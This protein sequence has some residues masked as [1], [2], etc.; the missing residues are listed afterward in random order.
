MI[1]SSLRIIFLTLLLGLSASFVRAQ[2]TLATAM[3]ETN[4]FALRHDSAQTVIVYDSKDAGVIETSARLF[5]D[6]IKR[7]T[8]KTVAVST[9]PAANC[10]V[11]GTLGQSA[12][13]DKWAAEG[14]LADIDSIRG[15]W[16][17]YTIQLIRDPQPGV[18]T[19]LVIAGSDRRG[20]AYGLLSISELIGVSPWYWWA[21]VPV[22]KKSEIVLQV[23][24][25]VS[26]PPTVKYRGIF[27]NDED[28]GLTNWAKNT[29][30]PGTKIGPK[31]YDKVC[32]LMLRMKAN[33]L[34]PA[35]HGSSDPFNKYP[36]NK[37]IADSYAIVMGSTHCEPLLFNNATEWD[38][39]TMG[40][41]NFAQ[42]R[43]M[44]SK[45]LRQRVKENGR[46]ENVYTLALRGVHDKA[47][48]GSNKMVDRVRTLEAAI[49]DQ[50]DIL[51]DVIKKPLTDIP[52]AFT[53]YKEV[54]D[55]YS[56]GLKVPDEVTL[57]WADDN[58]GYMKRL[59]DPYE[60]KRSGRA[61]V[62]YHVSYLGRPHDYLWMGSNSPALMYEE[63]RKAYDTTAD[64]IWLLNVGD[65]KS[66]EF[67]M[68]FFIDMAW[69][70]NAF[71][72]TKVA[73]Y[74]A[75][76]LSRMFG[77]K[78]YRDYLDVTTNFYRLAFSR[79]PELMGWGY[80]WNVDQRA[81]HREKITDTEFS[82]VNYKE[83]E[84]RLADYDRIGKLADR[85]M[86]GLPKDQQPAFFQ[87]VY[88][89]VRGAE[90]MNRVHLNAQK[91]RM[92]ARQGRAATNGI[93]AD[94]EKY[95]RKLEALTAI[96][97]NQL[98]GKWNGM[99]QLRM[100][101]PTAYHQLP[102]MENIQLPDT[103]DFGIQA[104]GEDV[105][106]GVRSYNALPCF[107]P[108]LQRGYY[109]DI[110]NK[111][112]QSLSW[113]LTTSAPWIVVTRN[114]GE[115]LTENR[116]VVGVDWNKVPDGEENLL[117]TIEITANNIKKQVLVSAFNPAT[118]KREE[119]GGIYI[120]DNG[121]V[122]I[123]AAGFARKKENNKIKM[124]MINNLGFEDKCVQFG[125]PV[126]SKHSPTN[127]N[128]PYVEYDFYTFHAGQVDVYT[129][130]LP[131]YQLFN[132]PDFAGHE[133][134]NAETRFG[135]RIDGGAIMAP[136]TSTSEY[137]KAWYDNVVRNCAIGKS[138]LY[139]DKPGKHTL[140]VIC[141]TPGLV[142]QK[143]VID[144]GGMKRS[145]MGP[146]STR[147]SVRN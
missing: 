117:G 113:T 127:L 2:V 110:Y 75:K 91:N 56:H 131:T 80:E 5:S 36:E 121:I 122:S 95:Y 32:E 134:T 78:N 26:K 13:I 66:C 67:H 43:D 124:R 97:N 18:K 108:Y 65:I 125:N 126:Q 90:L 98:D 49:A 92:Y 102:P 3:N 81:E 87:L 129:Y 136:T 88:Y 1:K 50:R 16:E 27:I 52:Q 119:V 112:T 132:D 116:V 28:W 8:K 84:K 106:S 118:P 144:L 104:E 19:A 21:D 51:S 7:V 135:I 77:E 10:V 62:Y 30:E 100:G 70:I 41:W 12:L 35:M 22:A 55:V 141:G 96:Y 34:C 76:W 46:Y 6:D 29:F 85:L 57:I 45:V 139:I 23:T 128:S 59:S 94:V 9:K 61:G 72:Y 24:K 25:V 142:L 54:L 109:V 101:G 130:M 71:N 53:P 4:T 115:T 15:K 147:V 89:P 69:D 39:K 73:S 33:Y 58:Y 83:A 123:P 20:A 42:N 44:I 99:M 143:F 47:M 79:K 137:T 74:Q 140:R 48:A 64:R 86:S 60:Q 133:I 82:F 107:N 105:Q 145:Y 120:E 14:K 111:S 38:K 17:C 138:T 40:E 31:T 103:P 11:V 63:L 93:A 37:E 68:Q 146:P 114:N